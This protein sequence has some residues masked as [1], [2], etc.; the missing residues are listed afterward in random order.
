MVSSRCLVALE[1]T[2]MST[3]KV[4]LELPKSCQQW[5]LTLLLTIAFKAIKITITL[6]VDIPVAFR[7]EHGV[8]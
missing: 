6:R 3:L 8:F 2:G 5:E 1:A 4:I 7:G